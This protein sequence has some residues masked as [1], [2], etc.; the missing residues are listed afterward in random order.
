LAFDSIAES[1]FRR[2]AYPIDRQQVLFKVEGPALPFARSDNLANP[3][4]ESSPGH[5]HRRTHMFKTLFLAVALIASSAAA[6]PAMAF[7]NLYAT[8]SDARSH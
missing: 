8:N 3:T 6:V 1:Y 4:N 5:Q 2:G 7:V